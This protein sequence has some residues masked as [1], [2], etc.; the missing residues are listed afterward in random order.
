MQYQILLSYPQFNRANSIK[1]LAR[2]R[3]RPYG[4][5]GWESGLYDSDWV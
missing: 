3:Q 1:P 5:A 2:L 4:L